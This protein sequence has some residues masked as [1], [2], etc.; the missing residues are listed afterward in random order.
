MMIFETQYIFGEPP[1]GN[2]NL[3]FTA[4][5][6]PYSFSGKY[7]S[8]FWS[9]EAVLPDSALTTSETI[10]IS[11]TPQK[12]ILITENNVYQKKD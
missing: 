9:I 8:L 12:I 5:R 6:H 11:P 2:T 7:F 3:R 10:E 4:P 1:I